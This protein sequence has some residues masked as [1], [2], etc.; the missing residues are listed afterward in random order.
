M[1]TKERQTQGW[2]F[3][4]CNWGAKREEKWV[5]QQ[6]SKSVTDNNSGNGTKI[7]SKVDKYNFIFKS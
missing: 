1:N 5:A 2:G 4:T 7:L 6:L 3:F